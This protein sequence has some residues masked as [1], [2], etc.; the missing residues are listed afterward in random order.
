MTTT[1]ELLGPDDELRPTD[2]IRPLVPA[3]GDDYVN[4]KNCYSGKPQNHLKWVRVAQV[5]G[6]CWHGKTLAELDTAWTRFN[7]FNY[8]VVRGELP[9]S[10]TLR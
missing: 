6:E 9:P 3:A 10:H 1:I 8:E 5:I 2:W 7:R 4:S